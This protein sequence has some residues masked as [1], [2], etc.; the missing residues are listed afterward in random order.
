VQAE[1]VVR[2]PAGSVIT[3]RVAHDRAGEIKQEIVLST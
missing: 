2:A 1:W 3:V